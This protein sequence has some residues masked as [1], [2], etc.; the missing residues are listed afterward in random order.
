MEKISHGSPQISDIF[1]DQ[2]T[3]VVV[4]ENDDFS[5]LKCKNLLQF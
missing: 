2:V 3:T 4:E 5:N 1:T